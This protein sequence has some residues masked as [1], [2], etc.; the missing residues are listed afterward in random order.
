MIY[1]K[2]YNADDFRLGI[3]KPYVFD[4]FLDDNVFLSILDT[5]KSQ[6]FPWVMTHVLND[7]EENHLYNIQMCHLFYYQYKPADSAQMLFPLVQAIDPLAILKIK[8]NVLTNTDRIIEHGMH[9]DV[10]N[11]LE[12]PFIKTG[13]LYMN[14]CN[15]YTR[16]DSGQVDSVKNRFVIFPNTMK[17]TGT[18]TTDS[19][20]RMV[21]NINFI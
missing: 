10:D 6:S 13:I 7:T 18:T 15:G 19:P 16:F 1:G 8:A 3:D 2:V 9:V 14:T 5:M 4:N 21:I 20:F 17:H 11:K 12:C